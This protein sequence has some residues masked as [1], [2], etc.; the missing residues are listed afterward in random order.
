MPSCEFFPLEALRTNVLGSANVVEAAERNSVASLVFALAQPFA[1]AGLIQW[2]GSLGSVI[3]LTAIPFVIGLAVIPFA[4][5][6]K[7]KP[8]P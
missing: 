2:W 3:A 6:T 1:I 8:L 4:L 7:G 5:E